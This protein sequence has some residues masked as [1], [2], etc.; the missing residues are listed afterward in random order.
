MNFDHIVHGRT[1]AH[2]HIKSLQLL[3]ELGTAQLNTSEMLQRA[4]SNAIEYVKR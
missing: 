2:H 4:H 1:S 3:T